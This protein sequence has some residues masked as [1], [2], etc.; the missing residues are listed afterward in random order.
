MRD[1]I[2]T[3]WAKLREMNFTDKRQYIWEYYKLHLFL[4]GCGLFLLGS[5]INV[6]FINPPKHEYVY[7]AWQAGFI[8]PERLDEL[9]ERLTVI[10]PDPSRYVVSVRSYVLTGE[11]PRDQALITRFHALMTVG[12]IHGMLTTREGVYEG[13][14]FG[15]LVSPH[16]VLDFLR[17]DNPALYEEMSRRLLYLTFTPYEGEEIT[18]AAAINLSGLPMLAAVGIDMED[19]YLGVLVG[20]EYYHRIA[21][22]LTAMYEY[23]P[24]YTEYEAEYEA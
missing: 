12:D 4:I 8:H 16:V 18:I 24:E 20:S 3:E 19:L 7:F 21:A 6:W 9:G 17:E 10:V 2:K 23:V 15:I 11:P 1:F 22:A 5:L 14:V 13:A